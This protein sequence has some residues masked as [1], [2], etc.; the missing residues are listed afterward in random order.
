[1]SMPGES[2][3][4]AVNPTLIAVPLAG[5]GGLVSILQVSGMH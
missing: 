3:A 2:D 5:S 1:M 4:F